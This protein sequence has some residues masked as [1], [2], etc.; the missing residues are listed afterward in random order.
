MPLSKK[1]FEAIRKN[2]RKVI[3]DAALEVFAKEGYHASTV[4][5]IAKKA[6]ISQGLMY[7]YFKSKEELINELMIGM[8]EALM[9]E[10]MPVNPKE[11]FTKDHVV[12]MISMGIDLVVKDPKF[13]KLYFTV[14][15]QPDV[16]A[17][18]ID[19][20][21]EISGLYMKA[22]AKYFKDKGEKDPLTMTRYFSA[23]MDGIQMHIMIDPKTF[24]AEKV[25]KLLIEQ[26]T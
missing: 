12:K 22:M 4:G 10:F 6:G 23:V 26:F 7:N 20:M 13:W 17:I 2:R 24:P 15:L 1:Q 8:I 3:L 19:K 21:M 9:C 16:Y 25:K 14:F 5:A 18:V 11:K